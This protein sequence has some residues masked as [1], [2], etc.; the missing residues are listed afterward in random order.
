MEI[1]TEVR[2][3]GVEVYA[4]GE[5]VGV[6]DRAFW[7]EWVESIDQAPE[8]CLADCIRSGDSPVDIEI[9]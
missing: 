8:E 3:D 7:S 9:Q 1:E 2:P 5:K 6:V 4:D